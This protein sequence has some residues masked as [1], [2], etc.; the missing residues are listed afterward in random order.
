MGTCTSKRSWALAGAVLAALTLAS[1]G[2]AGHITN[3]SQGDALH[4]GSLNT[5]APTMS[6]SGQTTLDADMAGGV[7]AFFLDSTGQGLLGRTTS[8]ISTARGVHGQV[9][10]ASAGSQSS[11]VF[12]ENTSSTSGGIGVHGAHSGNGIG[13]FGETDGGS[14][15]GV[16][17][18]AGAGLAV[19]GFADQ[20]A[21]V[22]VAGFN[23]APGG[24]AGYFSG[25]VHVQ[26]MLSKSAGAFR[27]DHPLDPA[28]MYLQHS[29]VESPDML[30]VY[31]GNVRTGRRGF[32]T[33]LLP[34]YFE[35]LN[36]SF[37]YQLTIVGT[38]GWRARVVERIRG[39]RFRIQTDEPRVAVSW[40]VTGVRKDA[41]ANAHRVAPEVAKPFAERGRFLHPTLFGRPEASRIA[42]AGAAGELPG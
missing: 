37:R 4:L 24:Y 13:V 36:R 11:G 5:I 32:A 42:P 28:N 14:G 26:G 15:Y 2:G 17:G 25:R 41:Y 8:G 35:A 31:S 38:R 40:Q 10:N 20:A 19:L 22:G 18:A 33:V 34:R 21:G 3:P 23:T 30:N 7:Y 6:N 39:N 12:G 1:A 9:F 29:F 27:I 16:L